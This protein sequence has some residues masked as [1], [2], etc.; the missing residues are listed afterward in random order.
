[1]PAQEGW[2]YIL[3]PGDLPAYSRVAHNHPRAELPGHCSPFATVRALGFPGENAH[4]VSHRLRVAEAEQV[5]FQ[6]RL[7]SD[8]GVHH[9]CGFHLPER[10]SRLHG[11]PRDHPVN[12]QVGTPALAAILGNSMACLDYIEKKSTLKYS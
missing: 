2:Q 10:V 6:G 7:G 8:R 12:R 9:R 4:Q 3:L 11:P 1:M 5:L